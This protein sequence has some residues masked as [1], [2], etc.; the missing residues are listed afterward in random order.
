VSYVWLALATAFWLSL[1]Y[2]ALGPFSWMYGYSAGLE[3]IPV[4]LGLAKSGSTFSL[5]AP[6]LAGGLDRLSFWGSADPLNLEPI[7][8]PVLP[9]WLAN[10]VHMFVQRFVAIY[11]TARV[12]DEDL[13][14]DRT[15]STLAGVLHGC[16]SYFTAGEM[17]ALPAV[18]L[19]VWGLRRMPNFRRWGILAVLAGVGF[20]VFT[21]FTQ[22][23]PYLLV[24]TLGWFF[25]VMRECS[26]RLYMVVAL[27]FLA[28]GVVESPHLVAVLFNAPT[29]HR[30]L[31]PGEELRLSPGS[32]LFYE[33]EFDFF[34]QDRL[35][36]MVSTF[37]PPAL[38]VVAAV[39]AWQYRRERPECGRYLGIA[40]LYT[41][42]SLKVLFIVAQRLLGKVL[43]WV[44]GV[45]MIRFHTVSAS[46][47]VA[48]ITVMALLTII[49]LIRPAWLWPRVSKVAFGTLVLFLLIWPKIS[50]F[51]PL[52]IDGWGERNY[53]VRA[54]DE[55]RN[56]DRSLF[57]VASV[58]PLQPAY[59]YGQRLETADGWANLF[60]RV[61]RDLWLRVLEPL[62]TNLPKQRD[63]FDPPGGRPQD[64]YIFL[65][66]GLILP[67]FGDM[68]GE[69][70]SRALVEGFDLE[71]RFN[72]R[73][74]SLLNV[75]YL[76]SEYPLKADGL[77][78]VH[79]PTPP[80][81]VFRPRDYATG[82]F[83]GP[84]PGHSG[85]NAVARVQR[86]M[87]DLREAIRRRRTGKDIY[88]Y[89]NLTWL[90]RYRFVRRVEALPSGQAVLDRLSRMALEDLRETAL[91]DVADAGG[92]RR[93]EGLSAGT[94]GV[95]RYTPD[96]I[97]LSLENPGEGFLVIANTWNPFWRAEVDGRPRALVRTNHAQFGLVTRPGE[98]QVRLLYAP[99]YSAL[100]LLQRAVGSW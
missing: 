18:P 100:A 16:F 79:A 45:N 26:L 65:G 60:P 61:Y 35:L 94:V 25:I 9:P 93:G 49:P 59:A 1:E 36:R 75:K 38:L 92:V 13:G 50:L 73:L 23:L 34:A 72:L 52:M 29:S 69:E 41:L 64:H 2:V 78:L 81:A 84:R 74:L 7:L 76:L 67:G 97:R 42:L 32:L 51:Y 96:E 33:M 48:L 54:L 47:L 24:F 77:R 58:L 95:E 83:I 14:L 80:P 10:G 40:L 99:P 62:F 3:T 70:P 57:R 90:H 17:M 63:I 15:R 89:E 5:W 98:R 44:T 21:S 86:L 8:F 43:P 12:C 55:L 20:S 87:T 19:L 37:L 4:Y 53:Q 71:R 22:S 46:F 31:W 68:A 91:V 56:S 66:G 85:S 27:F 6:F 11:F 88:I 39:V 82:L 30:A 28:L